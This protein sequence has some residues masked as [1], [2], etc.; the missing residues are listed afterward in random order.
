MSMEPMPASPA[1]LSPVGSPFLPADG[2][3]PKAWKI[4]IY[5]TPGVGK[6]MMAT[7]APNPYFLDLENG[8][9]EFDVKKT[10]F[11]LT[12]LAEVIDCLRWVIKQDY[13][14]IV[15]DTVD[16]LERML[17]AKVVAAYNSDAK[18]PV[19]TVG[20]IPYGKGG[21][22]LAEEWRGFL[23]IL[24]KLNAAGK[25]VI[26]V[27]HEQ[28]VKFENPEDANYDYY[29]LNVHKK[30]APILTAKLDAL[31]FARFETLVKDKD[32]GKG[33]AVGTGERVIHAQQGA[34][35]IA[36]NRFGL[37]AKMK[38]DQTLFEKIK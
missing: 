32:E 7:H 26:L 20:E 29:T 17:S 12:T 8:L 38:L 5:G 30:A 27:G 18:R 31:L 37:P 25:N 1:V 10:P 6:S 11:V 4:G 35:F 15:I 28:I 9:R 23:S 22:V 36:K 13:K 2:F 24:D 16:E 21:D 34:S 14:T 3:A 19:K 33:K